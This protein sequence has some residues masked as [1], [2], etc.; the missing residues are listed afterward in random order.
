MPGTPKLNVEL[1]EE[2]YFALLKAIPRG[3]KRIVF[4]TLVDQVIEISK[5]RGV[6]GLASIISGSIALC[7]KKEKNS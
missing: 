5:K 2:Q 7:Q 6:E 1:T 4:S 3:M